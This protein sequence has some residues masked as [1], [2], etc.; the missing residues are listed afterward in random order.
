MSLAEV[1]PLLVTLNRVD[2]IKCP[3]TRAVFGRRLRRPPLW[4]ATARP[5]IGSRTVGA[6]TVE[7][8][9]P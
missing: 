5:A 7:P 3:T 2:C 1:A 4:A 6:M 9:E 8:A